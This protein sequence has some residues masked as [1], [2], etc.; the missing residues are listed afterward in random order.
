MGVASLVLGIISLVLSFIP[1]VGM[2]GIVLAILGLIFGIIDWVQKKKE[3]QKY[4]KAVAGVICSAIAIVM[5][6][7][8]TVLASVLVF[9]V[10]ENADEDS[11]KDIINTIKEYEY[12]DY[13][14]IEYKL[15]IELD[16]LDL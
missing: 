7:F 16:T 6:I 2:F 14:E 13:N 3:S 15:P 10:V 9:H 12:D 5:V 11:V 1:I 8:Y 4:G